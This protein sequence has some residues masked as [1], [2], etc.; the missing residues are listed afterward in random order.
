MRIVH[1]EAS[2]GWG[3]QEMRILL[4]SCLLAGRGHQVTLVCQPQS[5]LAARG[6][7]AG[8]P[9]VT[10]PMPK[11]F[12]PLSLTRLIR[13]F[14][15]LRPDVLVTH[16]SRDGWLGGMAGRLAGVGAIVR[17][18]HVS[19]PVSG[20]WMSRA[21]YT[22]LA[23]MLVTTGESLRATLAAQMGL[24]EQR[25]ASVPTGVDMSVFRPPGAPER[26]QS[27]ARFGW[28]DGCPVV[29]KAAVLRGWK[30][31]HHFIDA[32]ALVSRRHPEV[33]FLAAGG[34]DFSR[35]RQQVSSLGLQQVFTFAGHREDMP[36]VL[37]AL[38]IVVQAST[39][40]EGVPQALMQALA[41][42]RPVVATAV[43]SVGEL[44][45]HG[46]TGLLVP[47]GDSAAM[48]EAVVTL[49]EQPAL[50][51]RLAQNGRRLVESEYSAELMADHMEAVLARAIAIRGS[52]DRD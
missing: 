4:E 14:R 12:D 50:A 13:L 45:R 43:G 35:R 21:L 20:G 51:R 41:V 23:D 9:V 40:G 11:S 31:Y 38:D 18:R 47:P 42:G 19:T 49:I 48:A 33:Q 3:G 39:G 5:N 28:A 32:A 34:G 25:T 27:R 15:R 36:Q 16:S 26:A 17:V 10:M 24:P 37:G 6:K 30:G 46:E 7:A 22:R 2:L 1:T 44:V 52:R 29:G 8:L